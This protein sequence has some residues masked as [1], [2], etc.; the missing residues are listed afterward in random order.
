MGNR[1]IYVIE[2]ASE[3][4]EL[5]VREHEVIENADGEMDCPLD[6]I[7]RRYNMTWED[8]FQMQVKTVSFIQHGSD[9]RKVIHSISFEH[10]FYFQKNKESETRASK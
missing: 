1:F 3:S 4:K 8:L 2:T 9:K 7:L 5:L 6:I 10:L